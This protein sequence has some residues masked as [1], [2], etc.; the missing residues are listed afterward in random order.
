G[1]AAESVAWTYDDATGGNFGIGRLA[2]LTDP[3]GSTAY[4][5]ERRGLLRSEG[6]T[7]NGAPYTTAYT[8]DANGNRSRLTY[9]SGL[10]AQYTS[11]FADRPY[12]LTS[13][14]TTIVASASYLPF[15]PLTGLAF[16]NGMTRSVSYDAR[17]RTLEN[18]FTSASG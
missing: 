9:P 8:Y 12:S 18:K 6:K 1:S 14:T 3:T 17:Y 13:G 5:Y 10:A 2:T 11:D 7:I 16:G 4:Q 15:G